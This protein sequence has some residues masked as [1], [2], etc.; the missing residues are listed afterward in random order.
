MKKLNKNF[1]KA[2]FKFKATKP[3]NQE[4]LKKE[5][6]ELEEEINKFEKEFQIAKKGR[7]YRII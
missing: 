6:Q 3:E 7:R 5:I 4:K 1:F 2:I